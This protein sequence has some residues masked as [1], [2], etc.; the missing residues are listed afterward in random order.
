M[1]RRYAVV[2]DAIIGTDRGGPEIQVPLI[3]VQSSRDLILLQLMAFVC[4]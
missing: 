1:Q 3:Q 2:V 4:E